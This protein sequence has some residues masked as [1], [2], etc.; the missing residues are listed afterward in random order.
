MY[1]CHTENDKLMLERFHFNGNTETLRLLVFTQFRTEN[2]YALFPEL[3]WPAQTHQEK[4]EP[5]QATVR[6]L[7]YDLAKLTPFRVRWRCPARR[8]C[9]W[10]R[11]RGGRCAPSVPAPPCR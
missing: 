9:T 4:F 8:R 11:A 3:L 7:E 1:G 10:W 6:Q 2:R 5:E